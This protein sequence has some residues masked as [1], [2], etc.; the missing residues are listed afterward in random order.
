M[1]NMNDYHLNMCQVILQDN[2]IIKQFQFLNVTS[3]KLALLD[4][5]V[6]KR[7]ENFA[8]YSYVPQ[9]RDLWREVITTLQVWNVSSLM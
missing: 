7:F 4:F 1:K 6:I 5:I 3:M 2:N 8:L 9:E